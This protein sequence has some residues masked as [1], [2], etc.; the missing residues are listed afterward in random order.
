MLLAEDGVRVGL[1]G[2]ES[3]T[4]RVERVR[5]VTDWDVLVV[6]ALSPDARPIAEEAMAAAIPVVLG[7]EV[8][9][10]DPPPGPLILGVLEGWR[11]AAALATL[12]TDHEV[13]EIDLAWT[14]EGR[15]L[16]EGVAVSFPDPIG[17]LWAEPSE[18]DEAAGG[19]VAPT[20]GRWR[21]AL[22]TVTFASDRGVDRTMYGIADDRRFLDGLVLAA[23][24]LAAAEGAY[25]AGVSGPAD[26][27]GRF[28]D[29]ARVAGLEIA[30]FTP[31]G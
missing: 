31:A 24:G 30:S 18:P 16:D 5:D 2:D 3:K 14:E 26:P 6:P 17:A 13:L 22:A 9:D 7:E 10:L 23:A 20:S 29:I 15:P 4:P 25:P 27:G 28:L 8:R 19:L 21:G 1:F 12:A 11:L